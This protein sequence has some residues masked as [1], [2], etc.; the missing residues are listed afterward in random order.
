VLLLALAWVIAARWP[1]LAQTDRAAALVRVLEVVDG[2]TIRVMYGGRSESVRYIGINTP[3]THH[4]V[5]GEQPGGREA[6][7]VNRRLVGGKS[8]RL[9]LDVQ[10]RDRYGRLLAYVWVRGDDGSELMVNARLV[11]L[12]YAQVMTIPPNVRHAEHFR[13]LQGEARATG[14]GLWSGSSR[15]GWASGGRS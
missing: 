12:G 2:D 13:R 14:R 5:K 6:S 11:W 9:E 10:T 15:S 1:A 4:P 7:E 3:E 8:V